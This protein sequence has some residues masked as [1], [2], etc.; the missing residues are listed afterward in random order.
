MIYFTEV[1]LMKMKVVIILDR[2]SYYESISG[3]KVYD[4]TFMQGCY[5]NVNR[6]QKIFGQKFSIKGKMQFKRNSGR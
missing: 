6:R 5:E 3:A 1:L 4:K 2:G